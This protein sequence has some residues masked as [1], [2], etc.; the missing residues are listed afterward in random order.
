MKQKLLRFLKGIT[1]SI[2]IIL[3]GIFAIYSAAWFTFTKKAEIYISHIINDKSFKITGDAPK[4]S[5]YPLIPWTKFSGF[6]EHESGLIIE[7]PS[8]EYTG[9]PV[10]RQ[11]QFLEAPQGIKISANFLERTLNFDYASIQVRLPRF[12][13]PALREENLRI[14]QKS[15][16]P[17]IIDNIILK[18]GKLS[19][20]GN[21]T[22]SLDDNLQISANINARVVGMEDLFEE[23]AKDKGERTIAIARNFYNMMSQIERVTGEKDFETTL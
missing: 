23:L 6:I 19:V 10:D 3:T 13:P 4:F 14:W 20:K 12:T 5:G 7:S 22:L 1:I 11:T 2:L 15:D 9:F 21:G 8:L 17:F 16:D 18:S